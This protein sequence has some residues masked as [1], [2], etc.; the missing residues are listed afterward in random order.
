MIVNSPCIKVCKLDAVTHLCIGCYRTLSEIQDWPT[1]S[2]SKKL[3]V[4]DEIILRR[5]EFAAANDR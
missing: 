5:I 2:S 1:M 4:L 3:E